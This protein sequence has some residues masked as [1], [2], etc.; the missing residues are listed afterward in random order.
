MVQH[1]FEYQVV[2]FLRLET[3][4]VLRQF[5]PIMYDGGPNRRRIR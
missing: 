2:V 5:K 3:Q 4:R 1:V